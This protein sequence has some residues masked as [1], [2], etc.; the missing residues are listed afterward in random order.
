MN[1]NRL[2]PNR[3]KMVLP[4]EPGSRVALFLGLSSL[5][6]KFL[7]FSIVLP[8]ILLMQTL[9][10][11]QVAD[12]ARSLR[13]RS[14]ATIDGVMADIKLLQAIKNMQISTLLIQNDFG[15]LATADPDDIAND[16]RQTKRKFGGALKELLQITKAN[17]IASL[18]SVHDVADRINV[19]KVSFDAILTTLKEAQAEQASSGK[20]PSQ[21]LIL[22]AQAQVDGLYEQLD[23]MAEG[24]GLIVSA[25]NAE[26]TAS[27]EANGRS[28]DL[29]EHVLLTV[30]AAG[31]II[32][33]FI[34]VVLLKGVLKHLLSLATTTR[35]IADGNLSIPIPVFAANELNSMAEALGI[36]R[37]GLLET[38][39]LRA[40]QS[41]RDERAGREKRDAMVA[42][43]DGFEA[44][45]MGV[46]NQLG[47][48]VDLLRENA[49]GLTTT[50]NGTLRLSTEVARSSEQASAST[51]IVASAAE[52]LTHSI[53]EISIQMQSATTVS[54][55]AVADARATDE[56]V[57]RLNTAAEK[58][59]EVVQLIRSVARQTNLLALNAT[60]EAARAG[61]AGRGFSVVANEVKQLAAQSAEA[62]VEIQSQVDAIRAE[63]TQAV[64]AISRIVSTIEG[65][66][67]IT[68]AIASAVE[69]QGAATQEIARSVQDAASATVQVSQTI[70]EVTNTA[71]ETGDAAESLKTS[72]TELS[73]QARVLR[74]E[75][76]SFT[77]AVR[78]N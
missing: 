20:P 64:R 66:S 69:Q 33:G 74:S 2:E 58:I 56:T 4:S 67:R 35:S 36:F 51:Q 25:G 26:I 59:G 13:A 19:A 65:M 57:A 71:R 68:T 28:L 76:S 78:K 10:G 46:V 41:A 9:V 77:S 62:T 75:V 40:E 43:A 22:K 16:V 60:I 15:S 34:I 3:T 6:A 61:E 8:A 18:G 27:D 37:E 45:V 21:A 29:F 72:A 7:F 30:S 50:A 44:Q 48:A 39:R 14:S 42:L 49:Q 31:L 5:R 32:C 73:E 1:H 17:H 55:Q 38:E 63:T 24:V 70:G 52:E 11:W 53:E 12:H 23:P 47:N 54:G